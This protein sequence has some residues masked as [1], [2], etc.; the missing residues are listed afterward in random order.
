[1]AWPWWRWGGCCRVQM[2]EKTD[3]EKMT[4]QRCCIE[5][6]A[7]MSMRAGNRRETEKWKMEERVKRLLATPLPNA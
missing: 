7:K 1:M 5:T 6:R 4:R 3:K 2:L